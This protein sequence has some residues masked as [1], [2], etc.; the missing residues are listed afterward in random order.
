M[1][2]KL[3]DIVRKE[4]IFPD[5]GASSKEGV[6]SELARRLSQVVVGLDAAELLD[7]L[8]ER[9]NKASTGADQ[10]LAIPHA[11]ML[12]ASGLVV[13]IGRSCKGVEFG[14]LDNER[15]KIFFTIVSPARSVAQGE[16]TYLQAISLVCKLMRSASLR[17][18]ILAAKTADDI[19]DVIVSEE[20][21][22]ENRL[23]AGQ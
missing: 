7:K 17:N 22:R 6:L 21:A 1:A 8:I 2:G 18:Q 15:S 16:V 9:E 3:S 11:Q 14:A 19:Y 13:S 20:Q 23:V 10:G 5:L 12:S 4:W